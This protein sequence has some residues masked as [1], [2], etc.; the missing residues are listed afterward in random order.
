M[1]I[2]YLLFQEFENHGMSHHAFIAYGYE[3]VI[4]EGQIYKRV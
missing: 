1:A 4:P 2:G 3:P